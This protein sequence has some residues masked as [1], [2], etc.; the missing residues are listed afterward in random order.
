MMVSTSFQ[1]F[2][3]HDRDAHVALCWPSSTLTGDGTLA[4]MGQAVPP[5]IN[6]LGS[7]A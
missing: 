6:L 3:A 7:F 1:F 4:L 5:A 2:T